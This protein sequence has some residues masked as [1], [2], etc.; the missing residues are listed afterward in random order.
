MEEKQKYNLVV[1]GG[2]PAGY[3]AAVKAA[4]W[5]PYRIGRSGFPGRHLLKPWLYSDKDTAVFRRIV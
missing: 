2:G 5:I 3:T 4:E 1:I